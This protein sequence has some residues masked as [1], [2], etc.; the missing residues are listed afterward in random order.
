MS[1]ADV[2]V[3]VLEPATS[4]AFMTVAELKIAL[5]ITDATN[6][7]QLQWLIDVESATIAE[8]CNRVFAKEKVRETWR[9]LRQGRLFLTHWPVKETDIESITING[10]TLAAGLD[11]ELEEASGKVIFGGVCC[12][13]GDVYYGSIVVTYTGGFSLPDEA[14][15]PLKQATGLLVNVAQTDQKQ[16]ALSGIRMIMHKEKRIMFHPPSTASKGTSGSTGGTRAQV[17]TLLS[18]YTRL[19]I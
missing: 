6:D 12:G 19:W 17:N 8:L 11:Y 7:P 9:C 14:P 10:A 18:H 15:M 3:K 5:G 1:G 13:A 4:I 2:T 16:E